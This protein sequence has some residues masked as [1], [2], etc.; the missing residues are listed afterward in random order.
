[1]IP[2]N[3]KL[4][5]TLDVCWKIT[6]RMLKRSVGGDRLQ[7]SLVWMVVDTESE[8]VIFERTW[9]QAPH[10]IEVLLVR[11]FVDL[12][13]CKELEKLQD[14]AAEKAKN[15]I[16]TFHKEICSLLEE[17]MIEKE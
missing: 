6:K 15:N 12:H 10:L 1:M 17:G 9:W 14:Q 8:E 4:S 7:Y 16:N 11:D 5:D 13:G 3:A 2:N